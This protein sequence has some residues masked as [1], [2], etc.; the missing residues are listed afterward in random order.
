MRDA[1]SER[2][3]MLFLTNFP[4][5]QPNRSTPPDLFSI[6]QFLYNFPFLLPRRSLSV[7]I[8]S[9]DPPLLAIQAAGPV[10]RETRSSV[11]C[12]TSMYRDLRNSTSEGATT[13]PPNLS[14]PFLGRRSCTPLDSCRDALAARSTIFEPFS[15]FPLCPW[16]F[17]L[18]RLGDSARSS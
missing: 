18:S 16:I 17:S 5:S 4:R 11:R 2:V 12:Y 8:F 10:R 3:R 7:T 9:A 14:S 15:P 13:R 1:H 6:L